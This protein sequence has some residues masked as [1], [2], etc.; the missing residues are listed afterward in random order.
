[1]KKCFVLLPILILWF[2]SGQIS[3]QANANELNET[4]YDAI[5]SA[6]KTTFTLMDLVATNSA[7][8]KS[9]AFKKEKID[10]GKLSLNETYIDENTSKEERPGHPDSMESWMQRDIDPINNW[11]P[12]QSWSKQ[13]GL[14]IVESGLNRSNRTVRD[15]QNITIL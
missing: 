7:V 8:F 2:A 15:L 3:L 10:H 5:K 13:E 4:P 9:P 6:G 11:K 14:S 1:M 12:D